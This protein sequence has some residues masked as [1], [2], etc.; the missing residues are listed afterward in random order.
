MATYNPEDP[1]FKLVPFFQKGIDSIGFILKVDSNHNT[2]LNFVIQKEDYRNP[3]T[4]MD[5]LAVAVDSL[6]VNKPQSYKSPS[7]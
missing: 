3:D 2:I 7:K 1:T 6:M 4:L 5:I